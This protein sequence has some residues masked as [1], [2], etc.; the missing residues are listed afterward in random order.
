MK[1]LSLR[2]SNLLINTNNFNES[3]REVPGIACCLPI[4]RFIAGIVC[5]LY[6]IFDV[7]AVVGGLVFISIL[8]WSNEIQNINAE[9][10]WL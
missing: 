2:I 3:H 1:Y 7:I 5:V 4:I 8:H 10:G 6:C 9:V